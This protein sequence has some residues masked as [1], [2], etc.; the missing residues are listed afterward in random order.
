MEYKLFNR[1][2]EHCVHK[3]EY[4]LWAVEQKQTAP[5]HNSIDNPC[6]FSFIVLQQ[7]QP[8]ASSKENTRRPTKGNS[9]ATFFL[10]FV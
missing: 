9:K 7:T 6:A 3:I 10:W 8:A 4:T 1:L 2:W 5:S